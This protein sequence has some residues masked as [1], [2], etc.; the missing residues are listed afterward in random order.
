MELLLQDFRLS[1]ILS[2]LLRS[3]AKKSGSTDDVIRKAE[4]RAGRSS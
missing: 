1:T 2:W 4:S 3:I